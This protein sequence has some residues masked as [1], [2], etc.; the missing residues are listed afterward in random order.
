MITT[1]PALIIE[2]SPVVTHKN[3]HII[4]DPAVINDVDRR[5]GH[6]W[7]FQDYQNIVLYF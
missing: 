4:T 7:V 6:R 2:L 3:G 1:D 5:P